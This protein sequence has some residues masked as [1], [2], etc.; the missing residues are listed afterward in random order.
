MPV[1]FGR[2]AVKTKDSQLD[3]M[4]HLKKS[5]IQVKEEETCLPHAL[6][7]AIA[8][9]ENDPNYD[10]YRRGFRIIPVV[11]HLL[12]TTGIDLTNSGGIGEL[13]RFQEYYTDYRISVYGGLICEDIIFDGQNETEKRIYLLY[14]E[15]TPHYHVITNLTGAMAKC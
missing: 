7:I 3:V 10:S 2:T 13:T 12:Q 15:T 5:I 1:G 14:D 11:N 6:I 9:F 4:T 8:R